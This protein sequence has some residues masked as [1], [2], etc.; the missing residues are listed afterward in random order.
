MHPGMLLLL[1]VT[2]TLVLRS[3]DR[4]DVY[5]PVRTE[6]SRVVF[7]AS[8]G[9]LYSVAAADVDA[10][11]TAALEEER[12]NAAQPGPR[13]LKVTAEER[14]RLLAELANSRGGQPPEPQ[15]LLT[16]PPPEPSRVEREIE[17]DEEWHWRRQARAYEESV[18]RAQEHLELLEAT[19]REL[20]DEI[21]G[22]LSL[23]YQPRQFSY[24]TTRLAMTREQIPAARLA[25]TQARREY[26]Q[27][28]EDARRQG[29]LP[30]WLR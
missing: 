29:I 16:E 24:Q 5:G 15:R 10:A 28:R 25:V 6:G 9:A 17:R 4:I 23:G 3:G 30:G 14:D 21:Y 19:A 22:L 8:G 20:E 2:S 26:D 18:R 11:A 27:F 1:V 7:R 13:K 12:R